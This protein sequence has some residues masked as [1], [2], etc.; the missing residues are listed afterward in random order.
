M[1]LLLQRIQGFRVVALCDAVEATHAKAVESLRNRDD[2]KLFTDY[3]KFLEYSGMDAV[4]LSVRCKEQG[5][6]AAM[7]LETGKHVNSEVPAAHSIE[8]CWRIVLAQERTGLVYQ[9]AEQVRYAGFVEAWRKLVA[10]GAL[11][12]ITYAEGQYLHYIPERMLRNPKTGT[13]I[14]AAEWKAH[15]DA[16]RGWLATM[17][18]IHYVV[19]DLSPILKVI[20]DRV[21]EVVGMSTDSPSAAHPELAAPDMQAAL[22]KTAKGAILRMIVSFSQPQPSTEHHWQQIIG[23]Q[24]S[25]EWKRSAHDKP[26]MWLKSADS[27]DK[28]DMDW[29]MERPN[30]PPE[31]RETGHGGLDYHVHVAFRD[32][33]LGVRPL[34]F[35]VYKAMDVAAPSI[36]A[37][38]SIAQG[39][40]LLQVPDF[41][42][43]QKRPAGKPL[44]K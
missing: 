13:Y 42:P 26:K 17:P 35:D 8:D 11:G 2:V 36:F 37:A 43:S 24:G 32:A 1:L 12:K 22:M 40:R 9:L 5:A 30:D 18:P 16:V 38:D 20:D 33:I 23:T 34:E 14:P 28:T 29:T 41:R 15:P 31:A 25:V 19:H 10:E 21:V 39:S 4:M 6:M 3:E 7:A 27:P 44:P